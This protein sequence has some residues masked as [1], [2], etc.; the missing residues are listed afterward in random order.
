MAP[1]LRALGFFYYRTYACN[2]FPGFFSTL[3]QIG[4]WNF[5]WSSSAL[6][7]TLSLH[8][9]IVTPMVLELRALGFF[10]I[11]HMHVTVFQG[12]FST[13]FHIGTWNFPWSS[14]ELSYTSSSHFIIITPMVPEL[15]ALGFFTKGHMHVT[16]FRGFLSPKAGPLVMASITPASSFNLLTIFQKFFI[17]KSKIPSRSFGKVKFSQ[18][19]CITWTKISFKQFLAHLSRRLKWAFLITFCP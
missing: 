19:K 1:E 9:I 16:V 8:F 6:S 7:F 4:T 14:S 15:R 18:N 13:P 12:F 2:S 5:P 10:T 11:G 3:F 17:C